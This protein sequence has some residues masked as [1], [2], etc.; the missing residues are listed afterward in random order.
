[1]VSSD[2][3]ELKNNAPLALILPDAVIGPTIS[4]EPDTPNPLV[5][6]DW[7]IF[8]PLSNEEPEPY[9]LKNEPGWFTPVRLLSNVHW[10]AVT[11]VPA[12]LAKVVAAFVDPK[13]I[14]GVTSLPPK[15]NLPFI[16]VS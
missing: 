4:T 5:A 7:V 10:N 14:L 6:L 12:P 9:I 15:Y 16:K 2:K 13:L 3:D 1:M 8:K 11:L